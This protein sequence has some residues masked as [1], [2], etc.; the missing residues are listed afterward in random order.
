MVGRGGR[1]V[2]YGRPSIRSM[3]PATNAAAPDAMLASPCRR[4]GKRA[5]GAP[6]ADRLTSYAVL[7]TA[8]KAEPALRPLSIT[9]VSAP[10]QPPCE[11][12]GGNPAP[13]ESDHAP[14]VRRSPG[15]TGGSAPGYCPA[16][17]SCL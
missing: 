8:P 4:Q 10:A 3:I 6:D 12:E 16:C 15:A 17:Q 7:E 11:G 2:R 13:K 5:P 9:P 14:G 1:P